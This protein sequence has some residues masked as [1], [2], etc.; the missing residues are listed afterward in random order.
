MLRS[1]QAVDKPEAFVLTRHAW[2]EPAYGRAPPMLHYLKIR[3]HR[4]V[5]FH[6]WLGVGLDMDLKNE[7]FERK[8]LRVENRNGRKV[9]IEFGQ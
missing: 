1:K 8:M 3:F 2:T 9:T 6:R 7:K 4:A 5:K